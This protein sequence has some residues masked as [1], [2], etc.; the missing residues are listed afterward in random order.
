MEVREVRDDEATQAGELVVAAYRAVAGTPPVA[1]DGYAAELRAVAERA[2]VAV[3]LVALDDSGDG[4][5]PRSVMG[6]GQADGPT[7][8]RPVLGCVTY[9]PDDASPL[10]EHLRPGEVSMRMLA[11]APAAQGRGVG[12]ALVDACVDRAR[13]AGKERLVLHSG[14]WMHDAHRLYAAAGFR[15]VPERDWVPEP[16]IPLLAF[17]LD[18]GAHPDR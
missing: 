6:A 12:R 14:A 9:V 1:D 8:P 18:L 11:V 5:D 2:R 10:A 3:V 13:G 4:A 7:W 17:A 16:D 15:R